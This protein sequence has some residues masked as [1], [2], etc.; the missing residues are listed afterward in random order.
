MNV[1]ACFPHA[2]WEHIRLNRLFSIKNSQP[3]SQPLTTVVHA[4]YISDG[5]V[6]DWWQNCWNHAF[7]WKGTCGGIEFY[8]VFN[9]WGSFNCDLVAKTQQ[10]SSARLP[11]RNI[12]AWA[13]PA[14]Y[15][16]KTYVQTSEI[17][18][19]FLLFYI[20]NTLQIGWFGYRSKCLLHSFA[21]DDLAYRTKPDPSLLSMY[22][23]QFPPFQVKYF[24]SL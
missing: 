4:V 22:R 12:L 16:I 24:K 7:V 13:P 6:L 21:Y 8:K 3:S 17:L 14:W 19:L 2:A 18:R 23:L 9:H 11:S 10:Y 1:E 20:D 5:P 15:L